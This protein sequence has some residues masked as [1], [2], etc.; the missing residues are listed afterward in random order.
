MGSD[1][2]KSVLIRH[3]NTVESSSSSSSSEESTLERGEIKDDFPT[4]EELKKKLGRILGPNEEDEK[5]RFCWLINFLSFNRD[6]ILYSKKN[7]APTICVL[8]D[9]MKY[10]NLTKFN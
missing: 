8:R 7:H 1:L 4:I 3:F 5:R 2:V 9:E 6:W 10:L